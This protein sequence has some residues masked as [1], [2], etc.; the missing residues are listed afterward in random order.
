MMLICF[1]FKLLRKLIQNVN[2]NKY[3]KHKISFYKKNE[4]HIKK[5]KYIG[6]IILKNNILGIEYRKYYQ[7]NNYVYSNNCWN[8]RKI[9]TL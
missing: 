5:K 2:W 3:I 1:I 7:N 8:R 4:S 9:I 6:K